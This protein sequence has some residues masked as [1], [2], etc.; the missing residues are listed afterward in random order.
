MNFTFFRISF[1]VLFNKFKVRERL[2]V[3]MERVQH[4]EVELNNKTEESSDLKS[5][6]MIATAEAAEHAKQ[7]YI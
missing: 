3:A 2:K 4:L 7:V 5:K 1:R 6:L